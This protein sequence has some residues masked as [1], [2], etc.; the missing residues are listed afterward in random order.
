MAEP[1]YWLRRSLGRAPQDP[2]DDAP[3]GRRDSEK[4]H[5]EQP[6]RPI[7]NRLRGHP[8]VERQGRPAEAVGQG[9]LPDENISAFEAAGVRS[10]LARQ[11]Q[12]KRDELAAVPPDVR[13]ALAGR[14]SDGLVIDVRLAVLMKVVGRP[15][16]RRGLVE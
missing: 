14:R 11:V 2:P 16:E 12:P 13:D 7:Q 3:E 8:G 1:L 5:G 4:R 9:L 10:D 6:Q 15:G